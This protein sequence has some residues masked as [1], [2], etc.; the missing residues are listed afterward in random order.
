MKEGFRVLQCFD[1]RFH[2]NSQGGKAIS[3]DWPEAFH[4]R[5]VPQVDLIMQSSSMLTLLQRKRGKKSYPHLWVLDEVRR[6]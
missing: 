5:A 1:C 4:Y 6:G 2:C 3:K